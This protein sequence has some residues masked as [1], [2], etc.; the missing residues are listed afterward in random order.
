MTDKTNE[1]TG[2]S[3]CGT[4]KPATSCDSTKQETKPTESSSSCCPTTEKKEHKHEGGCC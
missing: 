4:A 3:C 2:D 1:K